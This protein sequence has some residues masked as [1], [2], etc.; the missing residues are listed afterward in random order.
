PARRMVAPLARVYGFDALLVPVGLL[1][2][3]ATVHDPLGALA[4]IPLAAILAVLAGERSTRV[5]AQLRAGDL[6]RIANRDPL[7]QLRTRSQLLAD[8]DDALAGPN[9]SLL[10]ILDL[11]GFKGFNDRFGHLR[12]DSLLSRF[13]TRLNEVC[14][15][16]GARAYRLGGDEL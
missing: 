4:L 2:A 6:E 13:A 7:T 16:N 15:E 14:T 11:D 12:G 5:E 10:A 1:A 8:I 3:M 9:R